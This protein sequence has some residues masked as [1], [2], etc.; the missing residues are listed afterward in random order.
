MQ[1]KYYMPKC[2]TPQKVLPYIQC[3]QPSPLLQLSSQ[4]TEVRNWIS[5][6]KL[7]FCYWWWRPRHLHSTKWSTHTCTTGRPRI[8]RNLVQTGTTPFKSQPKPGYLI[9]FDQI[10]PFLR[11]TLTLLFIRHFR[12]LHT[13]ANVRLPLYE[14]KWVCLRACHAIWNFC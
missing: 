13:Y 1:N 5:P 14:V 9:N 2:K 6:G 12:Q 8:M 3:P 10:A 11:K 4:L 7:G